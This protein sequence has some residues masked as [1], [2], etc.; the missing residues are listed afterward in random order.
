MS[1]LNRN[2][3]N[4]SIRPDLFERLCLLVEEGAE[5]INDD[6]LA[7][8]P[9]EREAEGYDQEDYESALAAKQQAAEIDNLLTRAANSG[10]RYL[11]IH[12]HE[13]GDDSY[14]FHAPE[15][16]DVP[17]GF[18][19]NPLPDTDFGRALGALVQYF[20]IHFMGEQGD[21]LI[22]RKS[23]GDLVSHPSLDDLV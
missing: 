11:L 10:E 14:F 7:L 9:H 19:F 16:F 4:L 15:G 6:V 20:G 3:V 8:K 12:R 17:E 2:S 21:G 23:E 13:D 5:K 1:E 18:C 22:V